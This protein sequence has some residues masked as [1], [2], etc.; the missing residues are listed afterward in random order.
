MARP[1]RQ[2]KRFDHW[3]WALGAI[4]SLSGMLHLTAIAQESNF[5]RIAL[6]ANQPTGVLRGTTGGTASLPGIVSNRDRHNRACLGFADSQPDHI[7]VLEQPFPN[8]TFQVRSNADTTL[9][10][11]RSDGTV[12]CG[13]DTGNQKDASISD[14][15]WTADTYRIWVGT[16]DPSLQ[17]GYTLTIQP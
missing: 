2:P 9:V 5:G 7:L 10:V 4:A 8:L 16:A 1:H 17:R 14:Q 11:Q 13:D 6:G 3:G 15:A 12:W